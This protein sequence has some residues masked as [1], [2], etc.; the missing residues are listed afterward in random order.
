VVMVLIKS[1]PWREDI[2]MFG[3]GELLEEPLIYKKSTLP[4]QWSEKDLIRDNRI[5]IK[6][7]NNTF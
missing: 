6:R 3:A 1:T 5:F 4:P 7:I 2:E